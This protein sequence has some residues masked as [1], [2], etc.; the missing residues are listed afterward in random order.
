MIEDESAAF[1]AMSCGFGF[2][3]ISLAAL[4]KTPE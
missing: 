1:S 4:V 3:P 2:H